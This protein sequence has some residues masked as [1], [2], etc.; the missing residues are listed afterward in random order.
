MHEI[1]EAQPARKLNRAELV[2]TIQP[3]T[4]CTI[5]ALGLAI[6]TTRCAS[7]VY[8]LCAAVLLLASTDIAGACDKPKS[9]MEATPSDVGAFFKGQG[10]TVL[11]LLGYSGAGY[12]DEAALAT[13]VTA[14]LE[15]YE[16]RTTIVNIGATID[17]I[18]RVYELAKQRG[19]VT[20]GIVSTQA[21][22]SNA[23][24]SPCVDHVFYVQ[25]PSWGGFVK[26]S[27][28]LSPTSEAMVAVSDH[29]V[30]IGGGEVSRDELI[31]A[32]RAGKDTTYVPAD[33]NHRIALEKAAKKGQAPPTDFRGAVDVVF[34]QGAPVKR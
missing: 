21:R 23:T 27:E 3:A 31:A 15:K 9:N 19:F 28:R 24:L 5:S 4:S 18:G 1:R 25:D 17:G 32:R 30:A 14:I 7:I 8:G 16:P 10:K 13:H 6:V 29:L 20:S 26:G 34:G 22:D 33:M 11:T 12:E 2:S